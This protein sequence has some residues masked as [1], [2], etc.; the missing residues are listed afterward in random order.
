MA[1]PHASPRR[2]AGSHPRDLDPV[3]TARVRAFDR[4]RDRDHSIE[5]SRTRRFLVTQ[6][7][8]VAVITS[9]LI[10]AR[11]TGAMPG[12]ATFFGGMALCGAVLLMTLAGWVTFKRAGLT[13]SL[14]TG[15]LYADSVVGIVG[16]YILGEF[17][18]PNLA[19]VAILVVMAPLFGVKK[20]AYGIATLQTVLYA[21][22]LAAREYDL[23]PYGWV[24]PREAFDATAGQYSTFIADSILGFM[25]LV[26]GCA[27]VAG[28]ASL[29]LLT[30]RDSLSVEVDKA[31]GRLAYANHEL[32][33]RNSALDSFNSALSHDLGSPLQSALLRTELLLSEGPPLTRDQTELVVEIRASIERMGQLTRELYKLST[34]GNELELR[35]SIDVGKLVRE[36][37]IDL[38]GAL[39]DTG[40]FVE[41]RGP[42]PPVFGNEPL[43]REVLQNLIQNAMK[44][45]DP[46]GPRILVE[47]I[48]GRN[49]TVAIAVEDN[50]AGIPEADRIRVFRPFVQLKSNHDGK[51]RGSGLAIVARIVSAHQGAIWV[52]SGHELGGAR[53]IF[54]LPAA[55]D[56][57][58]LS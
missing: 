34:M 8:I 5:R 52:E 3:K 19:T 22:M 37:H 47:S 27:L 13:T 31:T 35:T 11:L 10:G 39:V 30:S 26:Y 14:V 32:R 58:G 20:H 4:L 21:G 57:S 29:G 42:I 49:G 38:H 44:F 7:T 46:S 40:A 50:G 24:F 25:M 16:F 56:V 18:T 36:V 2:A 9:L 33:E 15:L 48:P 6:A 12:D 45:A 1:D 41:L 54:E 51:G 55:G 17:E 53:F 28:E 23:L 43:L